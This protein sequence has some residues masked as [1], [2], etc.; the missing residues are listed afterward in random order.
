MTS[1]GLLTYDALDTLS[2]TNIATIHEM[3]R[4]PDVLVGIIY[5]VSTFP[6]L[7]IYRDVLL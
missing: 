3:I 1:S 6:S 7:L 4:K 5:M 2:E